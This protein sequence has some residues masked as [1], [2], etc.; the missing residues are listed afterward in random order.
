[1]ANARGKSYYSG[2]GVPDFS[3]TTCNSRERVHHDQRGVRGHG[4]WRRVSLMN[5]L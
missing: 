1:M 5:V 4:L 3:V 2:R